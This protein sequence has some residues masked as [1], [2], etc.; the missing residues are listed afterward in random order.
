MMRGE[1]KPPVF[2]IQATSAGG[3]WRADAW[4]AALST[5]PRYDAA[6]TSATAAGDGRVGGYAR[7]A[8]EKV[9]ELLQP[10]GPSKPVESTLC[11]CKLSRK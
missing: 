4:R 9:L 6:N 5:I 2:P 10:D 1:T 3:R 11:I 7:G 8:V